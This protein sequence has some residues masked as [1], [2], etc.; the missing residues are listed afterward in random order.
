MNFAAIFFNQNY[1]HFYYVFISIS[2]PFIKQGKRIYSFRQ[3]ATANSFKIFSLFSY[4]ILML[5]IFVP[6]IN[7]AIFIKIE[8]RHGQ[9]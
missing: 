8:E 1:Y 6:P 2:S 9:I 3:K 7:Y 4:L 5:H